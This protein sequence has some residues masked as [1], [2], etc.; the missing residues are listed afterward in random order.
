MNLI[1]R[2]FGKKE[3]RVKSNPRAPFIVK[4]ELN[5]G[6]DDRPKQWFVYE[7]AEQFAN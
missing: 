2:L 3:R 4:L 5:S 1:K 6:E 7:K